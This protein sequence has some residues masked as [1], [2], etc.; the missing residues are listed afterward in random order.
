MTDLFVDASAVRAY[1]GVIDDGSQW[2]DGNIG[3]NVRAAGAFL[4]RA[5]GRQFTRETGTKLF[6]TDGQTLVR[7]P[8]LRSA[9]SVTLAGATR[10][11][12]QTYWL[13][14]DSSGVYTAIQFRAFHRT[15]GGPWWLSSSD[16]WDRGLD[17]PLGRH[18]S[19]LPNDLSITGDWGWDPYPE[20]LLLAVKALAAFYTKRRDALLS[21]TM[22]APDGAIFDYASL[23]IEAQ[24]FI[25]NWRQSVDVVAI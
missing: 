7:I 23:P 1:M 6:S 17:S 16:W 21:N 15:G 24:E 19:T 12:N 2:A 14:P 10:E 5:T 11:A 9:S 8:D 4:E 3:S 13:I 18:Y 25:R 22:Q 20:E